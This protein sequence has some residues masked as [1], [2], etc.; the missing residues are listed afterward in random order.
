MSN[1]NTSPWTEEVVAT[2][3]ELWQTQSASK[4]ANTI[5]E[6]HGIAMTRNSVVG[7]LFR[8][9]LK[10]SELPGTKKQRPKTTPLHGS[11]AGKSKPKP[12]LHI[13]A[14][15]G[16]GYRVTETVQGDMPLF[17][18]AHVEPLNK[19]ITE[20]GPDDC[21]FIAGDPVA[22][23]PGIYCGHPVATDRSFCPAHCRIVYQPAQTPKAKARPSWR[24]AA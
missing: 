9:G 13:V 17:S 15:G 5:S 18:C 19:T 6:R 22:D 1:Q 3:L 11:Q 12:R 7:R 10:V 14:N 24:R 20:L 21:R 4:L 8:M 2:L 16:G 23:G